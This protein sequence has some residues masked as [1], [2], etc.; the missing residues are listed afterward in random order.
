MIQ[1]IVFLKMLILFMAIL[2][3]L[4]E[5]FRLYKSIIKKEIF[6][7]RKGELTI[8]GLSISYILTLI[9]I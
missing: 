7:P 9:F 5:F 3:I 1:V 6:L 4:K 8:L 2:N